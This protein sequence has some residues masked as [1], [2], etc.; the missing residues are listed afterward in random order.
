M[1]RVMNGDGDSVGNS[2]GKT[3]VVYKR[4]AGHPKEDI[5]ILKIT[6][7]TSRVKSIQIRSTCPSNRRA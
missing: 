3:A 5:L 1:L 2:S 6:L 7:R 4:K